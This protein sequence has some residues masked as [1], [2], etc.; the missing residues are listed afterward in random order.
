M[1]SAGTLI[2][3]LTVPMVTD[4]IN[5]LEDL[6]SQSELRWLFRRDTAHDSLFSVSI[7]AGRQTDR[8]QTPPV[9]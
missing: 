3:F 8:Q 7:G 4:K 1:M 9:Q 6:A 2:A 5:S